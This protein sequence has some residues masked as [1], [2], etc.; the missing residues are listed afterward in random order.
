MIVGGGTGGHVYPGV[1]VAEAWLDMVP[2]GEVVFAGS[3]RGLEARVVPALGH[4]FVEVEAR[5]LKNAGLVERMRSLV[6]M[7]TAIVRGFCMLRS[8]R[9]TVVLGVGGYVS[10]PVVLAAALG[11]WPCAV[12]EQ[13]ARSGLTN[14]ILGRFVKRVYT[15]F[16]EAESDFPSGRVRE[17]GNPVREAFRQG[18]TQGDDTPPKLLLLGGSQGARVLNERLPA[19]I[20]ALKEQI[21]E[22]AVCH[23]TGRDR[24]EAVRD[25]YAELGVE[26]VRVMA[27][28][29]DMAAEV[30][31]ANMVV[32]RAGAT[33]VAE[34]ACVGRPAL[35]IPF[36]H[37]ADDHQTAN[38]AS[39]VSAGAALMEN[40]GT[41]NDEELI[42]TLTQLFR[43][44]EKLA[45]M[46]TRARERGRP[47]AAAAIVR[48][49]GDLCRLDG[50]EHE[51]AA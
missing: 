4:P 12:A 2:G 20:A 44:P 41:L 7:P 39:L 13:N 45:E 47:D 3:A 51:E 16:P 21:P 35:F 42:R 36:P 37:A 8:Q 33:T 9:P 32:A 25:R 29:E 40:E 24:D 10:G 26:G 30:L 50:F 28:I 49:L 27:F 23:Q 1:A 18:Y 46:A 31:A 6:R 11:G 5:R 22:L 17:L 19:V 15:A 48:D 14:R 43:A 38:A 34:L